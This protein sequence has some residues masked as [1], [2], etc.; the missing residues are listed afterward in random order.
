MGDFIKEFWKY[1]HTLWNLLH[2]LEQVGWDLW[3]L[4]KEIPCILS[5]LWPLLGL[6][7][8]VYLWCW[9]KGLPF[10]TKAKSFRYGEVKG[11]LSPVQ[12][13]VLMLG[14]HINAV[15]ELLWLQW[16]IISFDG[17]RGI[18]KQD[19]QRL[20]EYDLLQPPP[21]GARTVADPK[22]AAECI[23]ELQA[24]VRELP[25]HVEK[26][27]I[28]YFVQLKETATAT[29]CIAQL[30]VLSQELPPSLEKTAA[31]YLARLNEA[32]TD[33]KSAM[34]CMAALDAIFQEIEP[35]FNE[36][37]AEH[38]A[39]LRRAMSPSVKI[40][41][42]TAI[43]RWKQQGMRV[44]VK[45]QPYEFKTCFD[46]HEVFTETDAL[47]EYSAWIM[48]RH[49]AAM[50][51]EVQ[52]VK[53]F[54]GNIVSQVRI[55][56]GF[57]APLYLLEGL[58]AKY[59]E[60]WPRVVRKYGTTRAHDNDD[61]TRIQLYQ[62]F[63]WL[64]WGPSVPICM[65]DRGRDSA[66]RWGDKEKA[67]FQYGYGDEGNSILLQCPNEEVF[68]NLLKRNDHAPRAN[69]IS[70]TGNIFYKDLIL[71]KAN[72]QSNEPIIE[73]L[74]AGIGPEFLKAGGA[75]LILNLDPKTPFGAG[76]Q[77]AAAYLG[78]YYGAYLWV[79]FAICDS[80]AKSSSQP[81]GKYG[82]TW[83]N[84][85]PYFVHGNI[86]E[87]N[88]YQHVSRLAAI[89]AADGA[90]Q[91]LKE[92]PDVKLK[93]IC[94]VDHSNCG[95]RL[96]QSGALGDRATILHY[97]LNVKNRYP[98]DFKNLLLPQSANDQQYEKPRL[99][100]KGM[101]VPMDGCK[102]PSAIDDFLSSLD[103]EPASEYPSLVRETA[104][105]Q[106]TSWHAHAESNGRPQHESDDYELVMP[107]NP[108]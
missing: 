70:V 38:L 80:E 104:M 94:A 86:A 18:T 60:K 62:F 105:V 74:K 49:E 57:F 108:R 81:E 77:E 44:L 16:M 100:I 64:I 99:R 101:T 66:C 39:Q 43:E 58:L 85:L 15:G 98:S 106:D 2:D 95:N 36:A 1:H 34:E 7:L 17:W 103:K 68:N 22:T 8:P 53:H 90:K 63:C 65:N 30:H 25:P 19:V 12:H 9:I 102:L 14:L 96:L 28:N 37:A 20:A 56:Q 59:E 71:N 13:F 5:D 92:H 11:Y 6:A 47:H 50:P 79:L 45:K 41:R 69:R 46:L 33:R 4:I 93:Y 29:D 32:A 87:G 55:E 23:A 91:I 107:T 73:K 61:L 75:N 48:E 35:H 52:N 97:L 72:K 89:A 76:D 82:E 26:T 10:L 42:V 40:D 67:L 54:S 51:G 31:N 21:R 78:T 88:S 27:T 3:D 83:R 84:L 24:I